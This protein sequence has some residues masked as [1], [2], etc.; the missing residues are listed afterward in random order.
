[1]RRGRAHQVRPLPLHQIGPPR[2]RS[3]AIEPPQPPIQSVAIKGDLVSVRGTYTGMKSYQSV[4][5]DTIQVPS[6]TACLVR[7]GVT[8]I[9]DCPR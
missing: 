3:V 7:P 4:I 2:R 6:V 8:N 1:M 9:A 5:G